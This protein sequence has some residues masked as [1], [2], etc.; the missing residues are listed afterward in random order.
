MAPILGLFVHG[1]VPVGV[2]ED[3]A[4]RPCQIDSNT[5]ATCGG[6]EAEDTFIQVET[7]Y[8]LL[9]VLSLDRSVKSNIDVAMEIQ[10]LL[11]DVEHFSHLSEDDTF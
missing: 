9:A 7:V 6:Y 1:W 3:D 10:E 5:S 8:Q 11:E 2:V 4:V